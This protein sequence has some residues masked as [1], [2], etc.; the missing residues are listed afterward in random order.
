MSENLKIITNIEDVRLYFN[1]VKKCP[2]LNKEREEEIFSLLYDKKTTEHEKKKL[3][4]EL[5]EGNLRFVISIA[6]QYQNNGLEI[7]D[8]ISEG[9]IGLIKA[10]EKYDP[11]SGNK[12]ISYAVWWVKQNIM[13]SINE[14]GRTIRIPSNLIQETQKAKRE[15]VL[16][17]IF[18]DSDIDITYTLPTCIDLNKE[19]DTEGNMLIDLIRDPNEQNPED[20]LNPNDE[21]K[22]EVRKLLNILDERE[23]TI[24]EKY[25]GLNGFEVSL[26][27]LGEEYNCTKERVRQLREKAIKKLR[28]ESYNLL[29]NF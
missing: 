12:F 25:Y 24:I 1:D 17:E 23:R 29:K 22:Q 5:I 3:K 21:I 20:I 13:S 11:K 8:L 28:N 14:N 16:D 7:L 6:K 10:L 26:E 19:I 15:N 18:N 4:K 27:D 2:V 9:N